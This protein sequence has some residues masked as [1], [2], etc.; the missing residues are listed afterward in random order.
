MARTTYCWYRHCALPV[1]KPGTPNQYAICASHLA[2]E[3]RE[4]CHFCSSPAAK[5]DIVC[6]GHSMDMRRPT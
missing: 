1:A 2:K 5:N 3:K 6:A 4:E